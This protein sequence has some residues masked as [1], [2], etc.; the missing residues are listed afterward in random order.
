MLTYYKSSLSVFAGILF[1][2]VIAC[3]QQPSGFH[4]IRADEFKEMLSKDSGAVLDVRTPGEYQ[5]GHITQA[6][7]LDITQSDFE[8]QIKKLDMDKTYYVYCRSGNRSSRASAIMTKL[9]FKKV[10]NI[11]DT[12]DHILQSGV[13]VSKGE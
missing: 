7:S 13:P 12:I 1:F 8:E 4:S 6:L 10:I 5:S 3:A 9:G 11:K 2:T